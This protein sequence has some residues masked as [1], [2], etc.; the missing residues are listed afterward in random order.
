MDTLSIGN[1]IRELRKNLGLSQEKFSGLT[2]IQ[3]SYIA[4]METGKKDP[5]YN[6]IVSLLDTTS[7]N[8]HWLLK[9]EG[10]MLLDKQRAT[11][12]AE[13]ANKALDLSKREE[14]MMAMFRELL[15][16]EQEEVLQLARKEKKLADMRARLEALERGKRSA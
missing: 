11:E 1:R 2:G 8:G 14:V 7:V 6:A 13:P 10:K 5:S 9:G 3:R 16:I 15:E 12:A 4:A